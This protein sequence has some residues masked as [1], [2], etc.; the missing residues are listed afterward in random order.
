[1]TWVRLLSIS[2]CMSCQKRAPTANT[3]QRLARSERIRLVPH[4]VGAP[5]AAICHGTVGGLG[6]TTGCRRCAAIAR[7]SCELDDGEAALSGRWAGRSEGL[8]PLA[9]GFP[10]FVRIQ[11]ALDVRCY[12]SAL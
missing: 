2:L 3:V 5:A 12:P 4:H 6:D 8:Q 10:Y 7:S 1:M 9:L 11:F